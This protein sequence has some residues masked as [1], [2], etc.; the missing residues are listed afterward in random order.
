ML[1][2]EF[3]FILGTRTERGAIQNGYSKSVSFFLG[4][5]FSYTKNVCSNESL[6]S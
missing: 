3:I 5:Y 6:N 4:L 1:K 2:F